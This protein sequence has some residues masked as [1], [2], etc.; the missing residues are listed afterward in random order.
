MAA[1]RMAGTTTRENEELRRHVDH[2]DAAIGGMVVVFERLRL[3]RDQ[4]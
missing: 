1:E 2:T 3:D 4:A